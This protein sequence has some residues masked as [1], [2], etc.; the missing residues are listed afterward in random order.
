MPEI[1]HLIS[2][3]KRDVQAAKLFRLLFSFPHFPRKDNEYPAVKEVVIGNFLRKP[4]MSSRYP[5]GMQLPLGLLL[6]LAMKG[7]ALGEQRPQ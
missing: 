5:Q 1:N 6:T 7:S 3:T 4:G 2:Q